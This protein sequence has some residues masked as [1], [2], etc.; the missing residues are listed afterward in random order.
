M[1]PR[2]RNSSGPV[3]AMPKHK[4]AGQTTVL[5]K[6]TANI[7]RKRLQCRSHPQR[8]LTHPRPCC[9][10]TR[11]RRRSLQGHNRGVSEFKVRG[12]NRPYADAAIAHAAFTRSRVEG[13]LA[14]QHLSPKQPFKPIKCAGSQTDHSLHCAFE[15]RQNK[16]GF[17]PRV[18]RD[19]RSSRYAKMR[20][21]GATFN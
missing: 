15:C 19:Q 21:T 6:M 7:D 11:R 2:S 18:S 3:E 9:G 12:T 16:I 8:P 20:F 10:A 13:Y 1:E 5:T 17:C 4:Q 14:A